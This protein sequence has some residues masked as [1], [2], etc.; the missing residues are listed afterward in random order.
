MAPMADEKKLAKSLVPTPEQLAEGAVKSLPAS[1]GSLLLTLYAVFQW[2]SVPASL[3]SQLSELRVAVDLWRGLYERA[4]SLRPLLDT[5]EA[6]AAPVFSAW[7]SFTAPVRELIAEWLPSLPM[8][9]LF[10][11]IAFVALICLPSILRLLLLRHSIE[12]NRQTLQD[13][14]GE[15][16]ILADKLSSRLGVLFEKL[17]KTF[18]FRHSSLRKNLFDFTAI[19]PPFDA[20]YKHELLEVG[21]VAHEARRAYEKA[22][23]EAP[24]NSDFTY[25]T[26]DFYDLYPLFMQRLSQAAR[27]SRTLERALSS[28]GA[29]RTFLLFAVILSGV[30]VLFVLFDLY[31]YRG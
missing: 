21:R 6:L 22:R 12:A 2:I 19:T 27:S 31:L 7:R 13:S 5:L 15:A 4:A 20:K 17:G 9:Q 10:I 24:A 23:K 1:V 3:L 18:V 8:P 26:A 14:W 11:D 29:A 30:G 25:E 28:I 16:V